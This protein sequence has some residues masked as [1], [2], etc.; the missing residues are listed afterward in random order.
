MKHAV[1]AFFHE[2]DCCLE[3]KLAAKMRARWSGPE[4]LLNDGQFWQAFRLFGRH[5]A[6]ANMVVERLFAQIHRCMDISDACLERVRVNGFLTECLSQHLKAGGDDPREQQATAAAAMG[7]PLAS[8]IPRGR[9]TTR[10]APGWMK[11]VNAMERKD[12][13]PR[14]KLQRLTERSALKADFHRLPLGEQSQWETRAEEDF[15]S[16]RLKVA[17]E[18]TLPAVEPL[19]HVTDA[20]PVCGLTGDGLPVNQQSFLKATGAGVDDSF[21]SWGTSLRKE[22]QDACFVKDACK[23]AKGR[24]V[25]VR[26]ACWQRHAGVCESKDAPI[27]PALAGTG[28]ALAQRAWKGDWQFQWMRIELSEPGA[29]ET[30]K[31]GGFYWCASTRGSNPLLTL[32]LAG[33]PGDAPGTVR[34]SVQD[35]HLVVLN[36]VSIVKRLLGGEVPQEGQCL[37]VQLVKCVPLDNPSGP[38]GV[39]LITESLARESVV[40]CVLQAR[41]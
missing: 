39:S 19:E 23:I 26:R 12:G 37:S 13:P 27:Y 32:F 35:M 8:A 17:L 31:A 2:D 1:K 16:K 38:L 3:P 20:A 25:T 33:E 36:N 28:T 9:R 14:S 29:P 4:A 30:M 15:M 10:K 11:Y 41:A 24:A 34:F 18:A 6:I 40:D 21:R 7:A 22:F 5:A